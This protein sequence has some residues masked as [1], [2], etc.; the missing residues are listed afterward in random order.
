MEDASRRRLLLGT[1]TLAAGTLG[2][3]LARGEAPV[4]EER[5]AA[6]FDRIEW[7]AVGELIVEQTGSER[8]TVQAEAEVLPKVITEVRQRTLHVRL[9]PGR[10]QTRQA[11]RVRVGVRTLQVLRTLGAGE[12]HVA[13]A[14]SAD[15]LELDLGA[16]GGVLVDELVARRLALRMRGAGDVT[17]ARGRVDE[18][19]VSIEGSGGYIAASL[20]SRRSSVRIAGSGNA[21]VAVREDLLAQIVGSGEIGYLGDPVTRQEIS[22]AGRVSRLGS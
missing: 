1:V 3:Q 8:V 18:Q 2:W 5:P 22:G 16:A 15:A 10:L 12:V 19:T 14:L 6:A 7:N 21:Q 11:I 9:A 17:I 13:G 20:A 4:T